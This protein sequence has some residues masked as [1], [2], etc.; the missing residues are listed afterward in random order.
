MINKLKIG[1]LAFAFL[2]LVFVGASRANAQALSFTADTTVTIGS[3]NYTVL[4]GSAA[5]SME[6]GTS[7]LTVTIPLAS[8]FTLTSSDRYL[9]NNDQQVSQTCTSSLSSLVAS[10][11]LTIVITPDT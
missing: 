4:S 10:G 1:L 9:L 5:T 7:T 2:S 11:S 8:T 6:V 3:N